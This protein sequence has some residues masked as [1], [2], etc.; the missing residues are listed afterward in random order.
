VRP[1]SY[2]LHPGGRLSTR[3]PGER[4]RT[5]ILQLRP[6]LPGADHRRR[7]DQRQPVFDG[8]SFDQREDERFFGCVAPGLP[9]AARR[10]VLSFESEPLA[11]DLAVVGSGDRNAVSPPPTGST[12][13]SPPS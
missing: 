2:F 8:G 12:R 4:R 9:L 3:L 5:D 6:G 10:D 11:E 13:I 7:A 1:Q